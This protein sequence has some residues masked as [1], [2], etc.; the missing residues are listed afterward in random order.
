MKE[1]KGIV[2]I[3]AG[4]IDYFGVGAIEKLSDILRNYKGQGIKRAAVVTG[5]SSYRISGAWQ[6]IEEALNEEGFEFGHFDGISP[7]PTVDQIDEAV[8][9]LSP[10]DAELIVGIGGGS[11]LDA[12]KIIAVLL[13]NRGLNARD[14]Y[15]KGKRP[16]SALP[17]VAVN[18]THGTG[19]EIDRY[20]V[21]TVPELKD[22]SGL[23]L[24]CM[25]PEYA[26]DDPSLMLTLPKEQLLYTSLDALNHLVEAAT[27]TLSSAY[28]E[29]LAREGIKEIAKWLPLAVK[30]PE[31]LKAR[32]W[33]LYA[34]VLGGMAIDSGVVHITHPL[35]HTLSAIK[36]ELPHGL[37]LTVLLPSVL[38]AIYPAKKD[39]LQDILMPITGK[40]S[41]AK[42]LALKVENWIFSLGVTVKL[43]DIGFSEET[44]EEALQYLMASQEG[45]GSLYL[46]PVKIDRELVKR[47]YTESLEPIG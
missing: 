22:K 25:Y 6:R 37:G 7:N 24:D 32:Y 9:E 13:K 44:V 33:L 43:R 29:M 14:L 35:E 46:A 3:R 21:A 40:F 20:A 23:A 36:P 4:S 17:V 1:Q 5:R 12:S 16:Y 39:L 19:S 10:L 26:I 45:G 30:E 18:L 31:N 34:S 2:E 41:S 28:T 38:R 47:I 27:T 8:R 42:E 11:V 15:V